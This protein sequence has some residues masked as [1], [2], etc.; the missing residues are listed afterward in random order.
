MSLIVFCASH[1]DTI[2]RLFYLNEMINSCK[3]YNIN[4]IYISM[5]ISKIGIFSNI[6]ILLY[7]KLFLKFKANIFIQQK[8]YKQF[9]HLQILSQMSNIVDNVNQRIL[10]MDDDD[11][12]INNPPNDD[13]IIGL[14][15]DTR[16]RRP[17]E[18]FSGSITTF[19]YLK[20]YFDNINHK[21]GVMEDVKFTS[22][23]NTYKIW[24]N[25]IPW[26]HKRYWVGCHYWLKKLT[27]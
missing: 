4:D 3:K 9:E 25:N 5:S 14:Q 17:M 16:F 19:Q 15:N 20:N 1:I 8:E 23:L 27:N 21:I 26:V 12:L 11:Y 7:I 10:Y 6:F 24:E 22:L 2:K 13:N 18:D